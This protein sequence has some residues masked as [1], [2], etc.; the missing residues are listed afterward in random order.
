MN[1]TDLLKRCRQAAFLEDT[2]TDYTDSVILGQ[3]YDQMLQLY[4]RAVVKSRQGY[5]FQAQKIPVTAGLAT[6][7]IPA[8]AV[9]NTMERVQIA[10]D[11]TLDFA[12]LNRVDEGQAP[13]YELG[14][15]Q[16][17]QPARYTTRG[18][19]IV[20]LPLPDS[21]VYTLRV[22]FYCRP[23]RLVP[24]QSASTNGLITAVNNVS[25]TVTVSADTSSYDSAGSQTSM[26]AG[27]WS[28]DIISGNGTPAGLLNLSTDTTD[29]NWHDFVI[30]SASATASSHVW[31]FTDSTIDL[32][33][34]QVGDYIRAANQSEWPQISSDFHRT[35]ADATADKIL[36]ERRMSNP[37]L[38]Q[39]LADDL[40]RFLDLLQPRALNTPAAVVVAP[41]S[42]YRGLRRAWPVKY[43]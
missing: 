8:R 31:T 12:D 24:A 15:G 34:V 30:T 40:S 36:I 17:G 9:M 19:N 37:D 14:V 21:S 35:V 23:S 25:K 20:L 39:R 32:S 13:N 41:V 26:A 28:I 3:M 6:Y 2:A 4:E 7:P 38:T 22:E 33:A 43:P 42:M 29:G 5:W 1:T 16:T 27:T 10:Y 11:S 18:R